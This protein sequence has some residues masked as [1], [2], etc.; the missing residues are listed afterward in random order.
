MLACIFLFTLVSSL[1]KHDELDIKG[2]NND[3]G[4]QNDSIFFPCRY[5]KSAFIKKS[6]SISHK[7]EPLIANLQNKYFD[8]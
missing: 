1:N 5:N 6:E 7:G 4:G 3:L 2:K 8:R